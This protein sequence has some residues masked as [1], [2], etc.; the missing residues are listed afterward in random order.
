[1]GWEGK[2]K[3]RKEKERKEKRLGFERAKEG[4]RWRPMILKVV[5]FMERIRGFY[6]SIVGKRD[7]FSITPRCIVLFTLPCVLLRATCVAIQDVELRCD[8]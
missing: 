1:M 7:R 2:E 8:G 6:Q 5:C 3:E 4:E